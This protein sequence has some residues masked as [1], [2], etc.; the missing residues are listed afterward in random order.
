M[1]F[2]LVVNDK[3]V[4]AQYTG[5]TA[6]IYREQ[7]KHDLIEDIG[8]SSRMYFQKYAEAMKEGILDLENEAVYTT[9]CVT[10]VGAEQ[11]EKYMWA[12]IYAQNDIDTPL[13][14]KWLDSVEDYQ[15]ML[16][17]AVICFQTMIGNNPIVEA[18]EKVETS[19]NEKKSQQHS[20]KS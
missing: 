16:L 4:T 3:D 1:R 15:L 7:F 20:Q 11:L 6:R 9:L 10:A 12:C 8:K 17:Y 13:Y 14:E 2:N 18:E 19:E 5:K